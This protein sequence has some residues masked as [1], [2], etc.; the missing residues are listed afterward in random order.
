MKTAIL[1]DIH[2]NVEALDACLAHARHAGAERFIGLGDFV[3]YGAD[4]EAVVRRVRKLPGL[5]AVR[6]NHDE[7]LFTGRSSLA[8]AGLN[9]AIEWTR[10]QIRSAD[11]SF[12]RGLPLEHR[13]GEVLYVHAS[14]AEPARWTYIQSPEAAS[15]CLAATDAW[16]VFVGHVHEARV[17]YTTPGGAVR[18]LIPHA[19]VSVPLS[20]RSRYVISGGSVGQPRDGHATAAYVL[21]DEV[22]GTI[23]FQRVPYD[24]RATAGKIIAA[25]LEPSFARRLARGR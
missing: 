4:P 14:A 9:E 16:L 12:L 11:L 21:H 23:H 5:V 3:G 17:Y 20:R 6:G 8:P 19:S 10:T 1:A 25:G 13:E 18:E 24:Y 15:E 2:S 7:A 22:A